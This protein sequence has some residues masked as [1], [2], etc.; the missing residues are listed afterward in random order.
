MATGVRIF[1]GHMDREE[2]NSQVPPTLSIPH[3]PHH[4][5]THLSLPP[6]LCTRRGKTSPYSSNSSQRILNVTS[7]LNPR[8]ILEALSCAVKG[9]YFVPLCMEMKKGMSPV[10]PETFNTDMCRE[11][12]FLVLFKYSCMCMCVGSVLVYTGR[13]SRRKSQ[14]I[15]CLCVMGSL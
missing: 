10:L 9:T 15:N 5:S 7:V 11:W 8:K 6:C 12:R 1:V 14:A 2:I 4:L 3:L 13:L